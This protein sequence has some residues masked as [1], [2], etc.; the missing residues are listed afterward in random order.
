MA[1]TRTAT[2]SFARTSERASPT[3]MILMLTARVMFW[4]MRSRHRLLSSIRP[5]IAPMSSRRMTT[6]A[7]S[8]AIAVP[9]AC[10][11]NVI[12]ENDM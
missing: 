4:R 3:K 6:S 9:P 10:E 5:G 7:L 12:H 1:S 8:T 11:G 2:H